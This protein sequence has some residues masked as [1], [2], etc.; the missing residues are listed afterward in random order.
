M[1]IVCTAATLILL[2]LVMWGCG[3]KDIQDQDAPPS[4]PVVS[5]RVA[6]VQEMSMPETIAADGFVDA[7]DRERVTAPVDGTVVTLALEIDAAVN[8]GDTI[9]ILR[10]RDS[11]ASIAGARRLAEQAKTPQQREEAERAMKVAVDMQQLVPVIAGR[12]GAVVSKTSS[13]GQT[14]SAGDDLI[15]LV[16]LSTLDF[17]ASV[18]LRY[19]QNI[20]IGQT[21]G[22][23]FPSLP[24]STFTCKVAAVSAQ[25]DQ[26]SQAASV[27]LRFTDPTSKVADLLRVGMMGTAT[28]TVGEH[29]GVMVVPVAALLRDD[30]TDT[31][32][33]YTITPDS[34]AQAVAVTVG[35]VTDSLAEVASPS[36]HTEDPVIVE[37]NYEV[38]DSMRVTVSSESE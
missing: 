38:S 36:L 34:L 6:R 29:P 8:A 21:A 14:V 18:P 27:R 32:T 31:Y 3:G 33:L 30:L 19:L 10:T 16:D 20:K 26:G 25:S 2:G 9:A 37:G 24:A 22:I 11:D 7:V 15:E 13:S 5:V 28:I 12:S 23:V 1:K 35:V 17:I 4:S